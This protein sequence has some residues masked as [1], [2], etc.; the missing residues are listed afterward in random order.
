MFLALV[1]CVAYAQDNSKTING[2]QFVDLGLPSG[3]LWATCNVGASSPTDQGDYFAWGETETKEK[4]TWTYYKYGWYSPEARKCV[5]RKY[6]TNDG[7]VLLTLADDAAHVHWGSPCHIPTR[8]DFEELCSS[9]NCTWTW[10]G[11]GYKITSKRNG[12]S[13]FLPKT[14][15]KGETMWNSHQATGYWSSSVDMNSESYAYDIDFNQNMF[16]EYSGERC[17]GL[18]VRPVAEP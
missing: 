8:E 16:R 17:C 6:S 4:Y 18:S 5:L 14:C 9:A 15:Y 7:Y 12:N 10:T 3:L 13:I 11:S 2:H 1:C